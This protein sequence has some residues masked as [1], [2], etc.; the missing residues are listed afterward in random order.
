MIIEHYDLDAAAA[1][2]VVVGIAEDAGC[3]P[4]WLCLEIMQA[5]MRARIPETHPDLL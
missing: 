4:A 2:P 1:D 3:D 5:M